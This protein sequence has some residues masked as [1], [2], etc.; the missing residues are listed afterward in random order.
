ME[1]RDHFMCFLLVFGHQLIPQDQ[2]TNLTFL[3][4]SHFVNRWAHHFSC[5]IWKKY[6][7]LIQGLKQKRKVRRMYP[8]FWSEILEVVQDQLHTDQRERSLSSTVACREPKHASKPSQAYLKSWGRADL[9]VFPS[10][11]SRLQP[12]WACF[13]KEKKLKGEMYFYWGG[14]F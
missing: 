11:V 13:W 7:R 2:Y 14:Y 8:L 6:K 1:F 10:A 5:L 12:D 4:K 3:M 9:Q